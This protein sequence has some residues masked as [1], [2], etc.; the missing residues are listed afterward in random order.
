MAKIGI[1]VPSLWGHLNP[2]LALAKQ[3]KNRSHE[4][5]FYQIP[6][7]QSK[8]ENQGFTVFA[9]G[10]AEYSG[11]YLKQF[12]QQLGMRQGT[13][14]LHYWYDE[15]EKMTKVVCEEILDLIQQN[16][17]DLLL[18]DQVE[19]AGQAVAEY[20]RIP[21]ITL[22]NALVLNREP[23]IPPVFTS[24]SYQST[25]W[26]QLRN[27]IVY[28]LGDLMV[29]SSYKKR[30]F[31]YRNQWHLPKPKRD[32]VFSNS[33]IAYLSQQPED[34]DFPRQRK[35]TGFHYCGPFRDDTPSEISFPY[36]LLTDQ[37]LIYASLG[38]LQNTKFDV[39]SCIA[40]ACQ[41][42]DV[43]LV[44]SHGGGLTEEQVAQLVGDPLVVSYAPQLELLKQATLVITHGGLNTVLDALACGV[45]L[46][47]LPQGFEQPTIAARI[48]HTGVGAVIRYRN[49]QL[50]PKYLQKMIK[51][52]LKS[53]FL[54]YRKNAQRIQQKIAQEK[55]VVKAANIIE[56][57]LMKIRA[58]TH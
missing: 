19:P 43:Q 50:D 30:L 58:S 44:I 55:G 51:Q 23:S 42:L 9:I 16:S 24:W 14:I 34:F 28:Y 40:S 11:D 35:P 37:P 56:E 20:L 45:P 47:A 39:F 7:L 32:W 18:V 27:Q 26:G 6:E 1:I 54:N 21:F 4:V 46:V 41:D 33:P 17:V 13:D 25:P 31:N 49:Q 48:E 38:T 57:E 29:L 5:I 15:Q 3:L 53:E 52:V 12:V 22:C 36:D 2:T 10:Q 8:I